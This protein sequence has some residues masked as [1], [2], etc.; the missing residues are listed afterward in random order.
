MTGAMLTTLFQSIC[1]LALFLL[2]GFVLR[3]KVKVFQETFIPA[4][5]IG[6]FILLLLGPI[7]LGILPIPEEWIQ[8]W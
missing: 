7:G 2:I 3:A 8:I 6:G 5:V 1:F 4:S